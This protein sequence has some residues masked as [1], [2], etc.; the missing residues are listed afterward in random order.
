MLR[1]LS[2]PVK[3]TNF[4]EERTISY[5]ICSLLTYSCYQ[6]IFGNVFWGYIPWEGFPGIS[7]GEGGTGISWHDLKRCS[8]I[9]FKNK[10]V[11]ST[12]SKKRNSKL[13]WT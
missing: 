12:E 1:I 7:G 6:K 10:E 3:I 8:E 5:E 13:K 9:V 11:F 2:V 4:S